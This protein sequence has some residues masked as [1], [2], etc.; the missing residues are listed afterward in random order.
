VIQ[1][2]LADLVSVHRVHGHGTQLA[3]NVSPMQLR[4]DGFADFLLEQMAFAGVSSSCLGIEIT[5]TALIHD[6]ARSGREL[7][8]LAEAGVHISLDDFGTGYSSLS[9]LTQFPV[10]VVKVDKSFT[11]EVG[12]D[13]RKT[14]IVSAVVAVSHELGFT[15]VAEGVE[16]E[17]QAGRLLDLGCDHGQGYLFGRP[18]PIGEGLWR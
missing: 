5:E 6:P 10:N 15:V 8:R 4:E 17:E 18:L 2:A 9:W 11:D 16:T 3:I 14:A 13:D 7:R 12:I 1:R